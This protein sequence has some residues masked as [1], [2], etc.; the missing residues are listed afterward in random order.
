MTPTTDETAE[1]RGDDGDGLYGSVAGIVRKAGGGRR[2][3]ATQGISANGRA[4]NILITGGA[5]KLGTHLCRALTAGHEVTVFDRV[6]AEGYRS[7]LGDIRS[8]EALKQACAGMDAILHCAAVYDFA[9]FPPHEMAELNIMGTYAVLLAAEARGVP[10]VVFTS[11]DSTLGFW[12]KTVDVLPE[13]LPLD[14][15]HPLRPQDVYGT[16]KLAGEEICRSFSRKDTVRTI[17][18]RPAW[19]WFPELAPQYAGPLKTPGAL[20]RSLWSYVHVADLVHAF[21]LA[22]AHPE[23]QHGTY[24][25]AAKDTFA[26]TDTR[27]LLAEHYPAL[28]PETY[29]SVTGTQSLLCCDAARRDLGYEARFS[30]RDIVRDG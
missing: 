15:Q 5:G 17:V 2:R 29:A 26:R 4:M 14:E 27:D 20:A 22:L 10:Q 6:A 23:I 9:K 28:P 12:W 18:L 3:K 19:I 1:G 16:S 13:Y 21:S 7:V 11:S 30:W 8:Q 25:I 24:F